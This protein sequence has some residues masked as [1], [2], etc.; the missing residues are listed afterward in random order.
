MPRVGGNIR[1]LPRLVFS[2]FVLLDLSL[3]K[4]V[5]QSSLDPRLKI[6]SMAERSLWRN[7]ANGTVGSF[8]FSSPHRR[9]VGNDDSL[10]SRRCERTAAIGVRRGSLCADIRVHVCNV[11]V[12]FFGG[13]GQRIFD[14]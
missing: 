8:K 4:S 5:R 10:I 14:D 3:V 13:G 9:D 7:L 1:S 12:F 2:S 6:I 11:I